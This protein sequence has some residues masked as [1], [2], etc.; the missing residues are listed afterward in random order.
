M[1]VGKKEKQTK[2]CCSDIKDIKQTFSRALQGNP[3][4]TQKKILK[5]FV[6]LSGAVV[7]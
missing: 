3:E 6:A 4:R 2:Q 7:R 1:S 5:D